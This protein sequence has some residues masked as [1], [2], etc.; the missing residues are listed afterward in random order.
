MRVNKF[1]RSHSLHEN[2]VSDA[3]RHVSLQ[4]LFTLIKANDLFW[5]NIKV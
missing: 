1:Y 5:N 2:A 4:R 3:P